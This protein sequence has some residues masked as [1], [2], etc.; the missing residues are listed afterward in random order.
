MPMKGEKGMA[1]IE[2]TEKMLANADTYLS[3]S[4]KEGIVKW[5]ALACVED[6][7]KSSESGNLRPLLIERYG[8]KQQY[9]MGVLAQMYL[10]IDYEKQRFEMEEGG[11]KTVGAL[12]CCMSEA[13]FDEWAGSHV[14]SQINRFIRKKTS[15]ISDRAYEM[16][17]DFKTF[18]IMLDKAI[19]DL[20]NRR[21][22][23]VDRVCSALL[24]A[25]TP[26]TL[27]AMTSD[28]DK[29]NELVEQVQK[30]SAEK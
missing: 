28:I 11:K 17:N 18:S 23:P 22:D 27:A 3:L 13:C 4:V 21:N 12:D 1:F 8:V 7:G 25:F 26:E 2:I 20:L 10:H 9:L 16:M 14:Y 24:Q 6:S 15:D 19:Q 30:A 29:L 5:A